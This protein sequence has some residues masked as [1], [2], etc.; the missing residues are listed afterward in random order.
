MLASPHWLWLLW[1]LVALAVLPSS[2][3]A[4]CQPNGVTTRWIG[5]YGEDPFDEQAVLSCPAGEWVTQVRTQNGH[6]GIHHG[7]YSLNRVGLRCSDGSFVNQVSSD[8][9]GS[10]S[11]LEVTGRGDVY[12]E[13]GDDVDAISF[14]LHAGPGSEPVHVICPPLF[15]RG[16][17]TL[18]SGSVEVR[19]ERP[20]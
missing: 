15:D 11:E 12:L 3:W 17:V 4:D 2:V 1:L 19:C 20:F 13:I 16:P 6:S 7:V 14:G 10:A 8:T 9:W 18:I 5:R